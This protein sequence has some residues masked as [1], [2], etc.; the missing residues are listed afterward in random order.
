M[1]LFAPGDNK[2]WRGCEVFE[3]NGEIGTPDYNPKTRSLTQGFIPM[4]ER[5]AKRI[6]H[7]SPMSP[8]WNIDS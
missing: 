5:L 6:F 7:P 1:A 8:R 4:E 3:L 2:P